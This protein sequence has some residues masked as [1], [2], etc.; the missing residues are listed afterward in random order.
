MAG[1]SRIRPPGQYASTW[2]SSTSTTASGPFSNRAATGAGGPAGAAFFTSGWR[3]VDDV[4]AVRAGRGAAAA[5]GAGAGWAFPWAAVMAAASGAGP[6]DTARSAGAGVR[7]DAAGAGAAVGSRG[8]A[9][10]G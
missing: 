10:A 6:V 4:L 9:G 1:T 8:V 2:P 7:G 3:D 5:G